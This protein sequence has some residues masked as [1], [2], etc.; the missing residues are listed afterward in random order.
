MTTDLWMLAATALLQWVLI[1]TAATPRLLKNGIV[2][3]VGNRH[4][5]PRDVPEWAVRAQKASDNLA[6]NLPLFAVLVL[7][8]NVAGLQGDLSA[9]GAQIFVCARVL[10]AVLY[11]A[12]VAWL[13]TLVWAVSLVGLGLVGAA[14]F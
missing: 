11:I 7:V 12:G 6:E 8:V 9:M 10:H 14:L 5:E 1:L 13:R 4:A 3:S 2:Y